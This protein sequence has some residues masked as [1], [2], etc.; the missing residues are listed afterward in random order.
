ME[1]KILT[2]KNQFPT[3]EIIFSHIGKSKLFWESIFNHIHT[4]HP[5]FTEQWRFYSDYKSWL[6]KITRKSKTILWL[7]I[8]EGTF[9][10]TFYFSDKAESA[11]IESSISDKLKTEFKQAKRYNKIRPIT[12]LVNNHEAVEHIKTLIEVKLSIK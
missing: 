12:L 8:L 3:E 9:R 1:E 4:N 5:D 6:F 7:S 11:I 2:D 10:T